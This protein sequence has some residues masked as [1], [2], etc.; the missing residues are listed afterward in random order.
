MAG[1]AAVNQ[2]GESLVGLLVAR[3][4]LLAAEDKLGPVPAALDISQLPLSKLA[5]AAAEPTAGLTLTCTRIAMSDHPRPRQPARAVGDGATLALDISYLATAW[6]GSG[7]ADEQ[8]I[9]SWAMLELVSRPALDRSVLLGGTDVWRPDEMVQIIPDA[10]SD[11]AL[12]RLWGALGHKLR[13]C[14]C[15]TARVVRIGYG[16]GDDWPNVVATRFG[17]A[18]TDDALAG[19]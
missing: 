3:R 19:A 14:A 16:P 4:N 6:G 5:T 10:T 9:L 2:L 12:W 11:D 7:G 1:L 18:P 15:F 17:F 13:L 8:S